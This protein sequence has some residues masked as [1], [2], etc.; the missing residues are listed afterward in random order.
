MSIAWR[1]REDGNGVGYSQEYFRGMVSGLALAEALDSDTALA[2]H[3]FIVAR[4]YEHDPSLYPCALHLESS[5]PDEN[6]SRAES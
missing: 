4:G 6:H 2:I 3:D 1:E 5:A